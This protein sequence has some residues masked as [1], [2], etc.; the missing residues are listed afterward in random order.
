MALSG[1]RLPT[2]PSGVK[3]KKVELGGT[4]GNHLKLER[5]RS[6]SRLDAGGPN[7]EVCFGII[8]RLCRSS[9]LFSSFSRFLS[10][11]LF[12]AFLKNIALQSPKRDTH[13]GE[14]KHFGE[15]F[16]PSSE[17][18]PEHRPPRPQAGRSPTKPPG[19]HHRNQIAQCARP[20]PD[21][22]PLAAVCC[23]RR[24]RGGDGDGK[25][26]SSSSATQPHLLASETLR[27]TGFVGPAGSCAVPARRG[28]LHVLF[29]DPPRLDHADG[30]EDWRNRHGP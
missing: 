20:F 24:R 17:K 13:P 16:W 8:S 29:P 12:P 25:A 10:R 15:W 26:H 27:L 4:L 30:R 28:L 5:E 14:N 9:G 7:C 21:P 11:F 22:A 3:V 19:A 23:R 1:R 2:L 6:S 18:F